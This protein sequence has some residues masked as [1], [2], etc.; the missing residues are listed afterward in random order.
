M[1]WG[2]YWGGYSGGYWGRS[3]GSQGEQSGNQGGMW[4]I[5]SGQWKGDKKNII[6]S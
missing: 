4:E 2:R 5:G 6:A 1:G 3:T